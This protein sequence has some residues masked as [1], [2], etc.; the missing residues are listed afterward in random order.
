MNGGT[1]KT[2]LSIVAVLTTVAGGAPALA[3]TSAPPVAPVRQVHFDVSLAG[4][5]VGFAVGSS[6]RTSVGA[7]LGI[8]GNWWNYMVLGGRHFAES[9]GLSYE[10]K[11]GASGK[12]V[13][14]LARATAF[15]RRHFDHGRQ[16]DVGVKVSGFL[17][18]DDSDDDFGGGTFIGVNV[19][20]TWWQWRR[21]RFGSEMD[22]GRYTEG[23]PELGVNVAPLLL[24]LTIP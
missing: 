16:L 23:R 7:S 18:S 11:D 14:E 19:T 12:S 3:Q 5:S 22:V 6:P 4:L 8:G 17:H 15:V 2:I 10:A 9:G 21:L 20:G 13:V 1:V 24:R